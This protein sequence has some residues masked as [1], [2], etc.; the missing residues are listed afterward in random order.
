ME[1]KPTIAYVV[2]TFSGFTFFQ[3]VGKKRKSWYVKKT[4]IFHS[5]GRNTDLRSRSSIGEKGF[6][7][8]GS[9]G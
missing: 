8:H 9:D 4:A 5:R 2:E 6:D 1:G 3:R 7:P